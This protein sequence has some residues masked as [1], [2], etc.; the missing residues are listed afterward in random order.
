MA[1]LTAFK[2][3]LSI[4]AVIG[5]IAENVN[6]PFMAVAP[7]SLSMQVTNAMPCCQDKRLPDCGKA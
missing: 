2:R 6:S 5:L 1:L 7:A 3:I 4:L